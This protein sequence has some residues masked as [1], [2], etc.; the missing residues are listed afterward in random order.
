M[1]TAS[2]L[3]LDDA[4][5]SRARFY[6]RHVRRDR[7][8][9]ADCSHLDA[10]L[11]A[12]FAQG[13]H[14][15]LRIP[16]EF[17]RDLAGLANTGE[18]LVIDWYQSLQ[19]LE[20][21][22]AIQEILK[23]LA[24]T[25]QPRGQLLNLTLDGGPDDFLTAVE[26][27]H[28]LIRAGTVYQ[29]NHTTR[30]RA[31]FAGCPVQLYAALRAR[32]PA[33]YAALAYHPDDGHTLCLSP[34]LF[35]DIQH[36]MLR[37]QPMKGTA[38]NPPDAGAR[39]QAISALAQDSKN[40]A[41][42]AMIVDLLRNDLS[43]IAQLHSV[44][45]REPFAVAA[46]GGV[47]QMTSTIEARLRPEVCFADILRAAFPCGSITG[48]PKRMAMQCIHELEH[49]VPRGLYT[50]ALGYIEQ[51]PHGRRAKLNVAIRTL[52]IK[53]NQALFGSGGGITID[54][55]PADELAE[56]HTKASFLHLTPA[57]GLIETFAVRHGEALRLPMHLHR[58]EAS[59]RA[60][61]IPFER[62][63]I[64]LPDSD[65]GYAM[66]RLTLSPTGET[67]VSIK[68]IAPTILPVT[69]VLYP[70]PLPNRNPLRLHKT[71]W[72]AAYDQASAFAAAHG[73]FDAILINED[74]YLLEGAR[75]AIFLSIDGSWHTPPL[76]L[77]ILPS[78][79]RAQILANP[80]LIGADSIHE[81]TIP[82]A[83]LARTE[84]LILANSL[85]GILPAAFIHPEQTIYAGIENETNTNH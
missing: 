85:R 27:I 37:T 69:A 4:R 70:H 61:G 11:E 47:L 71:D 52:C 36:D 25:G 63:S 29:I 2:F 23:Q 32:Q 79:M 5:N 55:T 49:G 42:N 59:A 7:A 39:Q 6:Q 17:G 33:P 80:A 15:A 40:R 34:E 58:L 77:H 74:G 50:G 54:S 18:P 22:W 51:T 9:A 76:G 26:K 84:R 65:A 67:A 19:I 43:K 1:D 46:H 10:L 82:A 64:R 72:R 57:V 30:L 45:V 75:T 81:S 31:D 14:A 48:A 62:Q 66:G 73:A 56:L 44:R 21:E 16:Y 8:A 35:L 38:P 20:S 24:D 12:G 3:L 28:A 53:D 13:L 41:E 60:L 83:A 68:P 78:V